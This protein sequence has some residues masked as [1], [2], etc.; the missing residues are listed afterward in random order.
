MNLGRKIGVV[1][2]REFRNYRQLADHL[3]T[4]IYRGDSLVSGGASGAD[5]MAQRYAR[6][7]GIPITIFYPDYNHYGRGAGFVRNKAIAESSDR[8]VAFYAKGR[9]QQGGTANTIEWARKLGIPFEEFEE[10][11]L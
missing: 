10:Q 8:I 2:S 5:S 6:E 1:G 11:D 4:L 3:N 9:F 7:M